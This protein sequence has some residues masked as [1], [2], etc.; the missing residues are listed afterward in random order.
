MA[1]CGVLREILT[2]SKWQS[3][4]IATFVADAQNRLNEVL[5]C[6]G[7]KRRVIVEIDLISKE[8]TANTSRH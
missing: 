1:L 4:K 6:N 5:N 3:N 7:F 2:R 8:L